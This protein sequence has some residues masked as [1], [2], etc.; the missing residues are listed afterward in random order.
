MRRDSDWEEELNPS[1]C[2]E[3]SREKCAFVPKRD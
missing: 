2:M 1:T 3:D